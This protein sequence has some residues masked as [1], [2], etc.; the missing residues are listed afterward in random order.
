MAASVTFGALIEDGA[1]AIERLGCKHADLQRA[2]P[3]AKDHDGAESDP[4]QLWRSGRRAE[5]R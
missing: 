1:V 4:Q 5:L 2:N 3:L